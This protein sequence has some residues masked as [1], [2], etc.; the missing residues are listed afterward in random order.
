MRIGHAGIDVRAPS[1]A[2]RA[3]FGNRSP[4]PRRPTETLA[5]PSNIARAEALRSPS[6]RDPTKYPG[7]ALLT[8]ACNLAEDAHEDLGLRESI[9]GAF[10]DLSSTLR[11]VGTLPAAHDHPRPEQAAGG[12]HAPKPGFQFQLVFHHEVR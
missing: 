1:D 10:L 12:D 7:F 3:S 9:S 4:P 8:R 2:Q 11:G 6:F 5:R